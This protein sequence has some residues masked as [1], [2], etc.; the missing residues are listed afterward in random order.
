MEHKSDSN[1]NC[2]WYATYSRQRINARIGG[3]G[4]KRTRGHHPNDSIVEIGQNTEKSPGDL[5]R[6]VV[7]HTLVENYQVT[8]V[9]KTLKWVKKKKW[10]MRVTPIVVGARWN[11]S[12]GLGKET[13]GTRDQRKSVRIFRAKETRCHSGPSERPPVK[14]CGKRRKGWNDSNWQCFIYEWKVVL[15]FLYRLDKTTAHLP[16]EDY[17]KE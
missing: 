3:L 2:D 16:F 13:G 5:R 9:S 11:G 1:T 7:T 10:N 4:N 6:V 17:S 12:Q 8:L 15:P 14:T